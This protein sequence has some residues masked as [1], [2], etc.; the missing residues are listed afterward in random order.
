MDDVIRRIAARPNGSLTAVFVGADDRVVLELEIGEGT[1]HVD[2]LFLRH[3]EMLISDIGVAGVRI[4][5]SRGA[6]RPTRI[7]RLLWRE[8]NARLAG[9][10]TALLDLLVVGEHSWWSAVSNRVQELS[11]AA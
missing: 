9:S 10:E 4:A 5:V 8:L 2:E 7:D 1:A 11:H 3:I 6:G